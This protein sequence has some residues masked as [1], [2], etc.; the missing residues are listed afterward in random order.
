M[1]LKINPESL[2]ALNK[3]LT[4]DDKKELSDKVGLTVR[5]VQKVLS[6]DAKDYR[7]IVSTAIE[8]LEKKQTEAEQLEKRIKEVTKKQ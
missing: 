7:S 6:G 1:T 5:Q 3:E 2:N 4:A 8:M